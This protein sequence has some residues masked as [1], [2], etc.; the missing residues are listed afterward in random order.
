LLSSKG[1][2]ADKRFRS[3]WRGNAGKGAEK[4]KKLMKQLA[5][6]MG[7]PALDDMPLE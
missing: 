6:L 1:F 4:Q 2:N 3:S 5:D 7:K